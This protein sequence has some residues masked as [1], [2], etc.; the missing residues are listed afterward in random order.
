MK[1]SSMVETGSLPVDSLICTRPVGLKVSVCMSVMVRDI[2]IT[3]I[4]H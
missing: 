1:L 2:V 3:G 4:R